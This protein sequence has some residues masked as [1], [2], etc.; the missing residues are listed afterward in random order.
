MIAYILMGYLMA[1]LYLGYRRCQPVSTQ[2]TT[3]HQHYTVCTECK[4]QGPYR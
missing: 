4:Q 2:V 3:T 1:L